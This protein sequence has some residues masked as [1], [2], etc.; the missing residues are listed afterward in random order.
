MRRI[1]LAASVLV[2]A[3]CSSFSDLFSAHADVAA[4]AAGQS[5]SAE[6][7]AEMMG[8]AKGA[9]MNAETAEFI[10]SVWSDYTLFAQSVA[11]G[12]L[13]TDSATVAT[14]LWPQV[15]EAKGAIWYD[16]LAARREVASPA[17]ADSA[18][19]ADT[20]RALQHI[21][22]GVQATAAPEERAAARKKA[23][24][25]LAQLQQGA[26]FELLASQLSDDPGSKANGGWLP[27]A[28]PGAYVTAFDSAAWRLAPGQMTG[29]VETPFGYHIIRR[30]TMAES[31]DRVIAYLTQEAS[32]RLDSIYMDSLAIQYDLKV[33]A[34]APA[35]MRAGLA[36]KSGMRKSGKAISNYKGGKLTVAEY[37]R[38]LSALPPQFAAQVKDAS[39]EQ[40]TQFARALSTNQLLLAQADSAGITLPSDQW[41]AMAASYQGVIDTLKLSIGLGP[42][43]TD[44]SVALAEREK[45]A[46][47]RVDDF[48]NQVFAQ[49]ARLRPLPGALGQVLRDQ[50]GGKLSQPGITRAVELAAA[51]AAANAVPG[52]PGAGGPQAPG[53]PP[54]GVS[55]AAGPPPISAP[56]ASQP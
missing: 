13:R 23:Q 38:W 55:P 8:K 7:L 22:V 37:L 42:D 36:D 18:F 39:D 29:L 24:L 40:L 48:F 52:G 16:T 35:L 33:S 41:S 30:P 34:D 32:R 28:K 56:P 2:L 25:A 12:T 47:L 31:R 1:V 53:G 3:G 17:A 27:P 54:Q 6:Q 11:R 9:Q 46:Q 26:S 20:V 43:V 10:A 19:L 5:L 45:V 50:E 51:A 14:V 21:L 44:S 4:T 15:A 49:T